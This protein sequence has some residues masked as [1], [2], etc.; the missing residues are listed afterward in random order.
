MTEHYHDPSDFQYVRKLR[1]LVPESFDAIDNLSQ[2]AHG[3]GVEREIP[4]KYIE[5]ACIAVALTTQCPYCLDAHTKAA[6]AA[7]V[8]EKEIAEIVMVAAAM[9]AGA[10]YTHGL[11]AL[12]MFEDHSE[13][14][15]DD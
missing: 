10:G 2:Q 5:L 13:P 8:T 15:S 9:R 6:K 14:Q 11:M 7:G 3:D 1:Q 4:Y 12:R